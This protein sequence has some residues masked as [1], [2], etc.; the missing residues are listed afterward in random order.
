MYDIDSN[1]KC[2]C[3]SEKKYKNCCYKNNVILEASEGMW[4]KIDNDYYLENLF[5][6]AKFK[7]YYNDVYNKL[8]KQLYFAIGLDL[9]SNKSTRIIE[10]NGKKYYV[11]LVKT[12]KA[13]KSEMFE[14]AHEMQHMICG[15]E[16]F[17]YLEY[18]PYL[19]TY[20]ATLLNIIADPIV[21]NR[22]ISK[23]L[24]MKEYYS[25]AQG[26]H[27][28]IINNYLDIGDKEQDMWTIFVTV[29]KL[30]DGEL[31]GVPK[32][33]NI[34][35]QLVENKFPTLVNDIE[36]LYSYIKTKDY[37]NKDQAFDIYKYIISYYNIENEINIVY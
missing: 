27:Y 26:V 28:S 24:D 17:P 33:D 13:R 31:V 34:I 37:Y 9:R 2:P 16:G 1:E 6:I 35:Y 22:L 3:M 23:K 11:I 10:Y 30:I 15:L 21:N 5:K 29:E 25:Y 36:K 32:D 12:K 19:G 14:I 4:L 20:P 7:K 18:N 8:D